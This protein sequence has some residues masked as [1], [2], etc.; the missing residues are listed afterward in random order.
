MNRRLWAGL[1]VT[2]PGLVGCTPPGPSEFYR[3][4]LAARGEFVDSLARVVDEKT[5]KEKF[6]SAEK[7]HNDRL[8]EIKEGLDRTK[9]DQ[10]FQKLGRQ[11]FQLKN[12]EPADRQAMID[13]MTAYRDYCKNI[14]FINVRLKREKQRLERI[15]VL[16]VEAKAQAQ[17]DSKQPVAAS[18]ADF[19]NLNEMFDSLGKLSTANLRF[20]PH[21]VTKDH[22]DNLGKHGL[23]DD[24]I[25]LIL[26]FDTS[27]LEVKSDKLQAPKVPDYPQWAKDTD[28]RA[29]L[30]LIT[31][32]R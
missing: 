26:D 28:Q 3:S 27:D 24:D 5:A 17:L 4:A 16:E 30:F 20:V 19:P 21:G 18:K 11:N 6:K 14:V 10:N 23:T 22:I 15:H 31:P 8:S 7:V 2:L 32:R 29:K 1:L 13:G 9:Y 25:K 12:L